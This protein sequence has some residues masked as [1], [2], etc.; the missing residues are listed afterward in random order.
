MSLPSPPAGMPT[1][2]QPKRILSPSEWVQRQIKNLEAV[3]A[4]NYKVGIAY[5]KK[6][7]ISA[8]IAA[9]DRWAAQIK[10]AI[11][12]QSR[13]KALEATNMDEWYAYTSVLGPDRLVEG[14]KVRQ[15]EVN[16]F[17]TTW[18]PLL[19]EHVAKIDAM[20]AVTDKDM[21]ERML[22]NLRGLKSLKGAWRGRA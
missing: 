9:E 18:Q 21:E 5:P 15:K 19:A 1:K 17:V 8:A 4:E 20:P 16:D 22:A 11:E 12:K 7:P 14:V 3:G 2:A 10:K 13:K 6:D